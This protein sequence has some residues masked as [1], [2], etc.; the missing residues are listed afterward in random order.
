MALTCRGGTRPKTS[1]AKLERRIADEGQ[2]EVYKF[3]FSAMAEE[4][5]TRAMN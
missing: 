2:E 4:K 5:P 3:S 1:R